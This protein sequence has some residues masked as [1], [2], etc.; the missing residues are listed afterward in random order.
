MELFCRENKAMEINPPTSDALLQHVKRAAYQVSVWG[1]SQN[2]QQKR[3]RPGDGNGKRVGPP[4]KASSA[5][6]ELVKCSCKSE[7]G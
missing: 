5:C 3:P 6:M 2:S 7:K 1:T 4:T